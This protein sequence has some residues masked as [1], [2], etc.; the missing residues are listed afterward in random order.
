MDIIYLKQLK[1]QPIVGV[2][3]WERRVRQTIHFDLELATDISV[4]IKTDDVAYALNY[5]D[6]ADRV[7]RFVESSRFKLIETMAEEVA[8]ML[9]REFR[10]P[11]LR[12]KISKAGAVREV[13]DLGLIIERSQKL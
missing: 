2:Y 4:A 9:M 6:V 11:W 13:T 5:K 10:V 3:E 7:I 12:L 1:A 8:E